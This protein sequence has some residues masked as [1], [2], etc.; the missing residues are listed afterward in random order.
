MATKI[1]LEKENKKLKREIV[2]LLRRVTYLEGEEYY[3]AC[4][5]AYKSQNKD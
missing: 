5:D 3:N 4:V 1:Q 2:S